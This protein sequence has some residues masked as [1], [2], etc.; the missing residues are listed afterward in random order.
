M[1]R[2]ASLTVSICRVLWETSI[3][4][5]YKFK[6]RSFLFWLSVIIDV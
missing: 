4:W 2:S 5:Y 1:D 3:K 6:E